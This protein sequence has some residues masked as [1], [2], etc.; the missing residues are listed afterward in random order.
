MFFRKRAEHTNLHPILVLSCGRSGTSLLMQLLGSS[1]KVALERVYP[2]E[3]RFLTYL[4]HWSELLNQQWQNGNG[5]GPGSVFDVPGESVG[6]LPFEGCELWDGSEMSR[7]SFSAAWREFS[8]LAVARSKEV[9]PTHY[10][11]KVPYWLPSRLRSALPFKLILPIR[12]PRDV[13]LSVTAFDRKRGFPGFNRLADDDDWA[14]AKRFVSLSRG[15]SK[16]IRTEAASPEGYL[17]KYE[18]L[19]AD[20]RG[21]TEKLSRWLGLRLHPDAVLSE[22]ETLERHMT[23]NSVS[24]SV[25]R[26]R[27][28]MPAE[29]NAFFESELR[30]DLEHFGYDCIT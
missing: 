15:Q 27:R 16:F 17:I 20:I 21:E 4:V 24:E 9:G 2:F 10:A 18:S 12:D 30:E 14:F 6:A 28:E 1:P 29:L 25:E 11:E 23:S 19:A 5:W 26:W 8:R 3:A 7:L 13:F 22:S